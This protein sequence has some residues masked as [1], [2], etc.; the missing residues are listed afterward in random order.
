MTIT[1]DK[2]IKKIIYIII[3]YGFT[4][5]FYQYLGN[6]EL[7]TDE[8]LLF[9]AIV[10]KNF[11]DL[12]TLYNDQIAPILFIL[13]TKILLSILHSKELFFEINLILRFIPFLASLGSIVLFYKICKKFF[14]NEVVILGIFIF[15]TSPN[16]IYYSQEFKQYSLDVFFTLLIFYNYFNFNTY[17]YKKKLFL[18]LCAFFIPFFSHASIFA[19][20]SVVIHL[21]FLNFKSRNIIK[22]SKIISLGL[23][24]LISFLINYVYLIATNAQKDQIN[25]YWSNHFLPLPSSL[26]DVQIWL[27]VFGQFYTYSGFSIL[28]SLIILY[29]SVY[30]FKMLLKDRSNFLI[31]IIITFLLILLASIVGKYPFGGRLVLFFVPMF[32]L[33][34]LNAVNYYFIYDLKNYKFIFSFLLVLPFFIHFFASF[35]KITLPSG[36]INKLQKF[37]R[38]FLIKIN[39]D[40]LLLITK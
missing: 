15:S 30:G 24:F 7:W 21:F 19:L 36:D 10:N 29:L 16:L 25:E 8:I 4:I 35:D 9:E 38:E 39:F 11:L 6:R 22:I 3:F 27:K 13:T 12:T 17:S 32:Y 26:F 33:F 5:R 23:F 40:N 28:I 1:K 20:G 14:C 18:T 31:I 2:I 34:V 37:E